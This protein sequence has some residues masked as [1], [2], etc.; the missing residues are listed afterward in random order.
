MKNVQEVIRDLLKSG[1]KRIDNAVVKGVS[2]ARQDNYDRVAL[3]LARP[4]TGYILNEN[5]GEY[6]KSDDVRVIFVSSF[7]I[8]AILAD[9][10]DS[11]FAKRF[12]MQKPQM[13]ELALSY[14]KVDILQESVEANT[15]YVNPFSSSTEGRTID[16]DTIINH[17]TSIELGKRGLRFLAKLEDKMLDSAF[18]DITNDNEEEI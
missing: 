3:T 6:E 9:N 5:S 7:S 18:G 11:A 17:I 15:D 8:G 2:V 16:H 13:L 4:V 10:E 1:A 12:L 14:A